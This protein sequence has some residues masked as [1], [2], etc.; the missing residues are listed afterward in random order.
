MYHRSLHQKNLDFQLSLAKLL[1]TTWQVE[2]SSAAWLPWPFSRVPQ[3]IRLVALVTHS[4][5]SS[6]FISLFSYQVMTNQLARKP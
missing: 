5:S 1:G 4:N 2:M 3:P 6:V